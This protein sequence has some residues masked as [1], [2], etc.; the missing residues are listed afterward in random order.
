MEEQIQNFYRHGDVLF[1]RV[2]KP[3][4]LRIDGE[5]KDTHVVAYGEATGHH[6]R[7]TALGGAINAM[8]G[9]DEKVYVEIVEK[10]AKL[11]HEEHSAL[12]IQ[13]GFYEITIEQEYDYFERASRNV[14]D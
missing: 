1:R 11:S 3:K 7:L 10:A 9:F 2:E 12:S 6:H 14:V 8:K 5:Q 4:K 13:P